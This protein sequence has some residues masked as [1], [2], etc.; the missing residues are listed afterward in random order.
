MI[1]VFKARQ[2]PYHLFL[3][4]ALFVLILAA[5]GGEAEP[6]ATPTLPPTDEPTNTPEP[7]P[8]DTAVPTDTPELEPTE[9]EIAAA[10]ETAAPT[11][12]IEPTAIPRHEV[13]L[14]EPAELGTGWHTL[15]PGGDCP[16]GGR[17][18]AR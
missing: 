13:Y 17:P 8:T 16:G 4:V 2:L 14:P 9:T 5:C 6:T 7:L 10:T 3:T 18:R 1:Y 11:A 12:T 15:Y